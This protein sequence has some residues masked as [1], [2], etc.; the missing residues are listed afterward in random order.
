MPKRTEEEEAVELLTWDPSDGTEE[1][2]A[3]DDELPADEHFAGEPDDDEPPVE[4]AE[5]DGY[6]GQRPPELPQPDRARSHPDLPR[7]KSSSFKRFIS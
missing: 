2:E 1:D 5:D 3:C 6:S 7:V 4:A